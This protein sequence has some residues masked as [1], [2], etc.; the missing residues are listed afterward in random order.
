VSGTEPEGVP[1][2]GDALSGDTKP[3]G[4]DGTLGADTTGGEVAADET[5]ANSGTSDGSRRDP[6]QAA[7]ASRVG[8]DPARSDETKEGMDH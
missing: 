5:I 2:G 8:G 3:T 1:T 6:T 7:D 4:N